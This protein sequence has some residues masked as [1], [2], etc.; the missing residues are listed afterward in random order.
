MNAKESYAELAEALEDIQDE[1]KHLES[2]KVGE[3]EFSIEIFLA[4]I[5]SFWPFVLELK[6]QTQSIP[7]FGVHILQNDMT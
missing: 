6:L 5:G 3:K 2:V 1:I 7:A 4:L